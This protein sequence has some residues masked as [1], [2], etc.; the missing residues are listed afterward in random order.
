MRSSL[1]FEHIAT[2][3]CWPEVPLPQWDLFSGLV[4]HGGLTASQDFVPGAQRGNPEV[5]WSRS[6]WVR[7]GTSGKKKQVMTGEPGQNL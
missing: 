4:Q 7:V 6:W 5:F 3:S 1:G 2:P